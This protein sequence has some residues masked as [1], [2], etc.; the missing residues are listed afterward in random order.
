M[1]E[2]RTSLISEAAVQKLIEQ[3]DRGETPDISKFSTIPPYLDAIYS[4]LSKVTP[5]TANLKS[6]LSYLSTLRTKEQ[7]PR[8]RRGVLHIADAM[9]LAFK[10]NPLGRAIDRQN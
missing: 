10:N 2:K 4:A 6:Y 7:S 3:I 1:N 8:I 9:E 5:R